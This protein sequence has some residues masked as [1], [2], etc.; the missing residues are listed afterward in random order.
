[1]ETTRMPLWPT[2][3]TLPL[4][5]TTVTIMVSVFLSKSLPWL[6]SDRSVFIGLTVIGLVMCALAGPSQSFARFGFTDPVTLVGVALG[7][8]SG[9]VVVLTFAGAN[10]P[11]VNSYR[12]AAIALSLL[13]SAKYLIGLLRY[14]R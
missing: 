9:L 12:S 14:L 7:A 6:T 1:M 2:L 13:I 8:T 4:L 3:T 10:L 11:V 5:A